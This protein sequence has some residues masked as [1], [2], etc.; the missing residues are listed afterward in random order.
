[1]AANS[2][3]RLIVIYGAIAANL[4]ITAAK[5]IAAIFTGSSS[6]LSEAIHSVVDT[7]NE[8]L[9]LLGVH[10][11]RKPPDEMHPFGYGLELYF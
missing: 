1:M 10:R 2:S 5:F 3:H 4:V 8:L 7:G 6:M 9:L 11:S